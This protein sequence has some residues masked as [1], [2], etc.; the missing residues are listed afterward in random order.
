MKIETFDTEGVLMIVN[1]TKCKHYY[2]DK[3]FNYDYPE[4]LSELILKGIVHLITTAET[5][6]NLNF[7]FDKAT[8]D[9]NKWAYNTSYNYLNVEDGDLV[10]LISHAAFTQMCS[11]YKGDLGA[12]IENDWRIR[13]L[14]NPEAKIEKQTLEAQYPKIK[15][16]LG[17]NKVNVY[18]NTIVGENFFPAFTFLFEK[19]DAVDLDKITLVPIEFGG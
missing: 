3:E 13:N 9:L 4:G 19:M 7:I 6:E 5:V 17:L 11:S 15:L 10:Q 16:P 2:V 1:T 14:L 12:H 18:T 8:F